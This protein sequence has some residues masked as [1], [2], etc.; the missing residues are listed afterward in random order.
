MLTQEE[1]ELMAGVSVCNSNTIAGYNLSGTG[2]DLTAEP[3]EPCPTYEPWEPED[4]VRNREGTVIRTGLYLNDRKLLKTSFTGLETEITKEITAR[5]KADTEINDRL[6]IIEGGATG[7]GG[8]QSAI[9]DE[10]HSRSEADDSLK[11][12]LTGEANLRAAFDTKLENDLTNERTA[13]IEGDTTL[14]AQVNNLGTASRRNIGLSANEVPEILANGKLS[15]SVIP[16]MSI[17]NSHTVASEA[18]MLAIT[19]AGVG[20]LAIRTDTKETY[21]LTA[22]PASALANWMPLTSHQVTITPIDLGGTGRTDGLAQGVVPRAVADGTDL[23]TLTASAVYGAERPTGITNIPTG[24]S[25]TLFIL[26]SESINDQNGKQTYFDTN[27]GQMWI[28]NHENNT[29]H[30]WVEI[31]NPSI[32]RIKTARNLQIDLASQNPQ[33]FDGSSNATD[34]GVKNTLGIANGG[35]GRT[36]GKVTQIALQASPSDI[37][38]LYSTGTYQINGSKPTGY[39]SDEAQ[40]YGVL[41]VQNS[42]NADSSNDFVFQTLTTIDGNV[43]LRSRSGNP[44]SWGSW[45]KTA[46]KQVE[47]PWNSSFTMANGWSMQGTDSGFMVRNGDLF[48]NINAFQ[49]QSALPVNSNTLVATV[50]N[51][52]LFGVT[53]IETVAFP[54]KENRSDGFIEV[55]KTGQIYFHNYSVIPAQ[56]GSSYNIIRGHFKVP[57]K[58]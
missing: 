14:Q 22:L 4:M 5:E 37:D 44:A 43:W 9:A 51:V 58:P 21:I 6:S 57:I 24:A 20:D 8:W 36:D 50:P 29:W 26:E 56:S 1:L 30:D 2:N 41:V 46:F 39:P 17:S 42:G 32:D 53:R 49:T 15:P 52:E 23:N 34:I 16:A 25:G 12:E 35:T 3:F 54:G 7:S 55:N 48:I 40:A 31:T 47:V 11:S 33:A 27:T 38:A 45:K 28:R 13:R 19:G 18:E 10:A